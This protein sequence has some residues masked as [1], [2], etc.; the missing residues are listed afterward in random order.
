ME[1]KFIAI[2]W[3]QNYA[4]PVLPE[5]AVLQHVSHN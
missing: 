4:V 3:S 5:M 2:L 1:T